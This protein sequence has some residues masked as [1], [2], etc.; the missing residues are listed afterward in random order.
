[1]VS[2]L[3][4]NL[5]E[6]LVKA[7]L[8]NS[9]LFDIRFQAKKIGFIHIQAANLEFQIKH[10]HEFYIRHEW[11]SLLG[12]W[13]GLHGYQS[14][15]DNSVWFV[16]LL[17]KYLHWCRKCWFCLGR[18]KCQM[19]RWLLC[20]SEWRWDYPLWLANDLI[21]FWGSC[22]WRNSNRWQRLLCFCQLDKLGSKSSRTSKNRI[23]KIWCPDTRHRQ[24]RVT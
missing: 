4:F 3:W 2:G 11:L 21:T 7:I 10:L 8:R 20:L 13:L 15:G 9:A 12:I 6:Y 5:L 23:G 24:G 17:Q 22:N 14:Q 1:M 18:F 19:D 16:R